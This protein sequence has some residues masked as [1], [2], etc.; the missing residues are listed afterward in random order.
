MCICYQFMVIQVGQGV[1][2]MV[3]FHA[4]FRV[5][6]GPVLAP[7]GDLSQLSLALALVRVRVRVA[8]ETQAGTSKI[9]CAQI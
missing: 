9:K 5:P 8:R 7:I 3:V 2:S 4:V 1:A 6:R